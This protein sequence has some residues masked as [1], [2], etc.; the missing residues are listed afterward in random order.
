MRSTFWLILN[1]ITRF[2]VLETRFNKIE[3][4]FPEIAVKIS[5][6]YFGIKEEKSKIEFLKSVQQ[7]IAKL[8][9]EDI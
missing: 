8:F 7:D 3:K 6:K 4:R 9:D 2:L 1:V 5:Q